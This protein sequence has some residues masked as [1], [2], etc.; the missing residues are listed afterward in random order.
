MSEKIQHTKRE[1]F[2]LGLLGVSSGLGLTGCS[3]YT[4]EDD[5]KHIRMG[6]PDVSPHLDP[7]FATDAFSMRICR[8]LYPALVDFDQSS[9]PTPW[10][11][12]HWTWKSPT[13]LWVGLKAN[14]SFHHGKCLDPADVVATYRNI[15]DSAIASPL[16]GPLR[17]LISIDEQE[18]GVLFTWQKPDKLA[19]FRLT[20]PILPA[21]L[22]AQ[23][24]D[25][26]HAPIGTGNCR[27]VSLNDQHLQ[28]QRSDECL[29]S[30]IGVKDATVRLLKVVRGEL[31]IVQNDLSPEL[32][33]HA[34]SRNHL[35]VQSRLGSSFSYLGINFR[36]QH[37]AKRE[38]RLALASAIDRQKLVNT[39]L[40][41][42][43]TPS[44]GLF[45]PDHW[46]GL[47]TGTEGIP[48]DP[49]YARK[50]LT[51]AGYHDENPLRLTFKTSTDSTR[52]RLATVYQ[53]M[54]K[55]VGIELTVS[56]QDFGSFYHDIRQGR[57]QL[58]GLSWVGVKSPEIFEYAFASYSTPPTGANRG[59]YHDEECD[60]L[61]AQALA[62]SLLPNMAEKY[63]QLQ[64]HLLAQLPMIPLWHD[65][66]VMVARRAIKGY[67]L[68]ED[69]RYDALLEVSK[70]QYT[71]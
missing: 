17:L 16:K 53:D 43:A 56:S 38:V 59:F 44:N 6:V 70:T 60:Q 24:H 58:Y 66:Q 46:C 64:K 2:K 28:L 52:L 1:L 5:P 71:L 67:L 40:H 20:V 26:Q 57:F 30:F 62:E 61:I 45:T 50:L 36:D 27:F 37:L 14:I 54:L 51:Q 21:D 3:P 11:A 12:S 23:Q 8:L 29:L 18:N 15:L 48:F 7:R 68:A 55:A 65:H 22:L 25:F 19:L 9:L 63:L 31:D 39:L 42:L 13:Q 10:L 47:P 35:L 41:Q 69:G 49:D 4:P 32:I 34:K 33:Q